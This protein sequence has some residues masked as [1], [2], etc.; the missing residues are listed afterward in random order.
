[1]VAK[2]AAA[3]QQL[4]TAVM[5]R[6]VTA[7]V[8]QIEPVGAA[9]ALPLPQSFSGCGLLLFDVYIFFSVQS[10]HGAIGVCGGASIRH[11]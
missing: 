1:M 4:A 5:V 9:G 10:L 11:L 3:Q 6:P 8:G 7:L 2:R